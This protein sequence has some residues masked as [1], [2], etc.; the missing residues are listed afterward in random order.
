MHSV[1]GDAMG[2]G[3]AWPSGGDWCRQGCTQGKE[4]VDQ[5]G[6]SMVALSSSQGLTLLKRKRKKAQGF[7]SEVSHFFISVRPPL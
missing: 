2:A 6:W 1:N 5:H 3:H 7:K 4:K